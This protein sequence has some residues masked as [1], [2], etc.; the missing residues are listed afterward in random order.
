MQREEAVER[1]VV[2]RVAAPQ[3]RGDRVAHEGNGGEQVGDDLRTP[4]A[5][6]AP[7]QHV[8]H[9]G[10]G[11]HHEIDQHADHP[12]HFARR[13]V[14]AVVHAAEHVDVDRDEEHGRA[15]GVHVAD[16]PA[17]VHVA[18]DVLDGGEGMVHMRRVVHDEDDAGEDLHHQHD[19]KNAAERVP[20]VQVLRRREVQR[21]ALHQAHDRQAIIE[22]LS[23]GRGWL[24]V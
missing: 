20:V 23:E 7:G 6:L 2:D 18:H 16:H 19:G 3:Q 8:T 5:H 17:R 13:L 21:V 22:P 4:E 10:G 15:I 14:G 11:H 24:V 9:E 12:E 1:R